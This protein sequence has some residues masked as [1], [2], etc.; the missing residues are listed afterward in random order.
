MESKPLFA[1]REKRAAVLHGK[2]WAI[3]EANNKNSPKPCHLIGKGFVDR[4]GMD[5]RI[6][7]RF[8]TG[9]RLS[10]AINVIG[11]SPFFYFASGAWCAL[12]S[13]RRKTKNANQYTREQLNQF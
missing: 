12:S 2:K 6:R 13:K 7:L 4:E 5:F 9:E 8:T 11:A 3:A 10:D 1:S